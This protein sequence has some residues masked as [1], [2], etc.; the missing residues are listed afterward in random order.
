MKHVLLRT[1]MVGAVLAVA[2]GVARSD[3]SATVVSMAPR[4]NCVWCEEVRAPRRD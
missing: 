4:D 1:A 3:A 2:A